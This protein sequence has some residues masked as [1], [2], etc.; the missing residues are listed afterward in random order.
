MHAS[1]ALPLTFTEASL[2]GERHKVD[3]EDRRMQARAYAEW[4]AMLRGRACPSLEDLEATGLAG[5]CQLLLDL[6]QDAYDP[7]FVVIGGALLAE[8][9]LRQ[10]SRLSNAPAGSFLSLLAA[11]YR[12]VA[13][14]R[15]PLAFEGDNTS[16]RGHES[17]Y[18][19]ML[20]PLASDGVTVDFVYG[21][22]S[23]REGA[24]AGLASGIEA[25]LRPVLE[26]TDLPLAG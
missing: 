21:I 13:M 24:D 22:I 3:T 14:S 19:G 11:H 16:L 18:R 12:Q 9:G 10:V 23:W 2:G 26:L 7:E 25:E 20:L 1:T 5:P 8:C 6:R 4:T 17:S 15:Y